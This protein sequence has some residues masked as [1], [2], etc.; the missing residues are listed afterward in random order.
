[1]KFDSNFC[2]SN[3]NI[4]C[5]NIL[6]IRFIDEDSSMNPLIKWPG[7]KSRELDKIRKY[8]PSYTRYVE[9]FFGG[10]AMFFDLAPK[11]S[12][13]NDI[14]SSLIEFY[15]L[16]QKQDVTLRDLLLC[17]YNSFTNLIK[18]CDEN[19]S[20]ILKLYTSVSDNQMDNEELNLS[21]SDMIASLSDKINSGFSEKLLL[22]EE[23]FKL[24]IVKT[25]SDKI[26]RTIKNNKKKPFSDEDLKDNLIT[27]F[28][29]GYY[30]YFRDVY[31]DINLKR[32]SS[33]SIQ[34]AAANFCFMREYCYGSMFRYNANGE[35]NIP[36]G[37]K[38][39][40]KKDFK[41]KIDNMFNR[42]VETIFK[43]ADIYCSDFEDFFSKVQLQ[44]NDFMFLDPP[45]D[46]DFSDYE[47]KDFTKSDQERLAYSL[48]KTLAQFIL[49]IK[50]TD[51]I[52]SLYKDNFN[53]LSFDSQYTYNVRS[54]NN[55]NTEH[56]IITNLPV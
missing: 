56:L 24:Q 16:I 34:Y 45:Y 20:D 27:G 7:G 5:Y 10:G 22:D 8:I 55:R 40:N 43:N 12:A 13:I 4:L 14:S 51:F 47:G 38:S 28:T 49:I 9:P 44:E 30:M 36:Y 50:N 35:F 18:V 11:K 2:L 48:K 33:P 21:L 37:G 39:Y 25:A 46:T 41:G 1:M 53:I 23:S 52:H 17:Y 42:D 3:V 29:S 19:Y 32:I 15:K 6:I 31:N 26:Q 54:R